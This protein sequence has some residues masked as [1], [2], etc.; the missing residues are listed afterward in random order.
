MRY[1]LSVPVRNYE[2]AM[3]CDVLFVPPVGF[4]PTLRPF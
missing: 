2:D 4:E 1:R 3:A